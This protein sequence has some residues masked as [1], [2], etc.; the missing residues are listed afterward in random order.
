MIRA[1]AL[2]GLL[3]LSAAAQPAR[4]PEVVCDLTPAL[5]GVMA[6]S[7][8]TRHEL[9]KENAE[10]VQLTFRDIDPGAGTAK[11]LIGEG[12]S[13]VRTVGITSEKGAVVFLHELPG[14]SKM[15]VSIQAKST[16]EG[17]PAVATLHGWGHGD[18]TVKVMT[19]LCRMRAR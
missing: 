10:P 1:L 11:M 13:G 6:G 16:T 7:K 15:L 3:P 18:L 4:Q 5:V 8:L 12:A 19:G 2:C 17:S 14:S 9:V